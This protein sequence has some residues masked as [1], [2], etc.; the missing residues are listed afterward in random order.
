MKA[1]KP[2]ASRDRPVKAPKVQFMPEREWLA[3]K[4]RGKAQKLRRD[5]PAG[6][7]FYV[8]CWRAFHGVQ[9]A[10]PDVSKFMETYATSKAC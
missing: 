9:S 6:W 8:D 5:D 3:S 2:R 1:G 7:K 4:A 10:H